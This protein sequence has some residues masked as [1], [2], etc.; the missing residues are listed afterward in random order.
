MSD[1]PL[2]GVLPYYNLVL[3]GSLGARLVQVG[4]LVAQRMAVPFFNLDSTL[5]LREG[6]PADELRKLYGEAYLKRAETE[7]CREFALRRSTVM[8]V[9]AATLLDADNRERLLTAGCGLLLVCALDEA[10]RRLHVAH[11]A[12]FHDP[13]FR[14]SALHALKR[15]QGLLQFEGLTRLDTTILTVEQTADKAMRFWHATG[16]EA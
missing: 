4:T 1:Q 9:S 14:S 16:A 10:L 6:K 2:P 11:G 3:T 5:N 8:A 12:E 7:L 13:K 15:D